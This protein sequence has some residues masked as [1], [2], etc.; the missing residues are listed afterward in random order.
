M[1]SRVE[2]RKEDKQGNGATVGIINNS[3]S[4]A[5]WRKERTQ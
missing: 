3:A 1:A 5:I 2:G 4:S